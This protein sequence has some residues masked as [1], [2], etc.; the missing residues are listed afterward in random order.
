MNSNLPI[1]L[2]PEKLQAIT[3]AVQ[4]LVTELGPIL[5]SFSNEERELLRQTEAFS[6]P[7][8][9]KI[10]NYML[11]DPAFLQPE[12][13]VSAVQSDWKIIAALI[14]ISNALKQLSTGLD[15]TLL[16]INSE[17]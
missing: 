10:M 4:H 14:P 16:Q 9:E 5:I 8:I 6:T 15:D 2:S 11:T 7:L 1:D 13:N 12:L 3:D 17:L